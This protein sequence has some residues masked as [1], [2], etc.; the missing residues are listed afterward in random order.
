MEENTFRVGMWVSL[1][2]EEGR[3][4]TEGPNPAGRAVGGLRE[5]RTG[6]TSLTVHL[7]GS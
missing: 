2:S 1:W 6:R 3:E 7:K 4:L 5:V